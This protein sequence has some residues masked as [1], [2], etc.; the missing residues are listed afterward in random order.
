MSASQNFMSVLAAAAATLTTGDNSRTA[1]TVFGTIFNPASGGMCE[2]I[3]ITPLATTVASVVRFFKF[4]G[5]TN[6]LLFEV[7]LPAQ[8]VT[9]GAAVTSQ[10]LEAVDNPDIFP[11]IVPSGWTLRATVNDTQTGVKVQAEGG[12][13]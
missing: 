5:T 13:A 4:D 2:R 6:H 1:P 10:R 9:A 12:G 8:T 11:I 7:T 3:T